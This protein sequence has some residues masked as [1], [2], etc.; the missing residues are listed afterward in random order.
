[1]T[2]TTQQPLSAST[3]LPGHLRLDTDPVPSG[4]QTL[5]GDSY[6]FTVLSSRMIRMEYSTT[7]TFED[8]PSQ[9]ALNRNFEVP[10]FRVIDEDHQLQIITEHLHLS[11][12]KKPFSANGL[13]VQVKGN[14]SAY[15]SLWRYS[16]AGENLGGT[17][18]TLDEA[19][20][21]IPL[22]P[23]LMSRNGY[24]VLDDST[25]LLLED[26]GWFAPRTAGSTDLYFFGYGRDYRGC[27]RDFYRLSGRTPLLPRFALGNWWSRYHRYTA[28]GYKALMERFE[29]EGIPFSVA[30]LDMDWHLVDIDPR[31][32]SGWT[33]YT[34]NRELFPDPDEFA[35]WLHQ[36]GL[37]LTLNVHP[38]EG[39][40]AHE[41]AYAAVAR[42]LDID[43]TT[44]DP[45]V[46]DAT[47]P[48]FLAAYFE[49]IHHPLERSGV[50]FWWL[51]WQS[52][53]HSKIVGMDPLWI[54]NHLHFLDSGKE[55]KKPLTF[56]RYAGPGSHRYPIGFSGD[57][58]VTW[59]SLDFQP[60]FTTCASNI[61]YGWWSHDIGGHMGGYKDDELAVRWIQFGVFS[62]IMRLHSGASPFTGKEPWK[63]PA[64]AADA[65]TDFLRL[66]HR[67]VPYLHTMNHRASS[68]GLPLV[69]PM[70]YEYPEESP[71]YSVP[72]QYLFGTALIAAPITNPSDP[73]LHLGKAKAWLPNGTWIDFFTGIIYKGDRSINLYRPLH[74]IPVLA[75]A[76][77]I[78]PLTH[79]SELSNG[80]QNPGKFEI[81]VFAGASGTFD[82]IEDSD[83]ADTMPVRTPMRLDWDKGTFTIGPATGELSHIPTARNFELTFVGFEA[84][85][86][87]HATAGA[88]E[89]NA[90]STFNAATNTTI[91]RLG[92]IPVTSELT[93]TVA[94]GMKLGGNEA[95][96]RIFE[97][98]ADAQ[99]DFA[100]KE[101]I[102]AKV[103]SGR[104]LPVL[105]SDLQALDLEPN[106]LGCILELLLADTTD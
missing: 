71:A 10:V 2:L 76:G 94:G 17:A 78:V 26:N 16:E 104:P 33:G 106:L 75:R 45:I 61:G 40:R 41:D 25:S 9:L 21:A 35:A 68:E 28:E 8:R 100:T 85:M 53:S 48:A 83:D 67:L 88:E 81:R 95:I 14:L 7:G 89:L 58:I 74:H 4:A 51:D 59:E 101:S 57:T 82:L 102:F 20:G 62:P 56:S 22:E 43:P 60:H 46:F 15:H 6:R 39:I 103:S 93:V 87:F 91:L 34:W 37:R 63:Y 27:L 73:K 23:G 11:Y 24:S 42:D 80:T 44:E 65:M 38:A 19:D 92:D 105:V 36:K 31:H 70:Y 69:E 49:H 52:G 77:A 84:G 55:G 96:K 90:T 97:R 72:N 50:D 79:Q 54:L 32:G 98:L 99:I 29:A 1:M 30:V 12:N 86:A 3:F 18:R 47:D 64:A 66:R 5:L 13:T